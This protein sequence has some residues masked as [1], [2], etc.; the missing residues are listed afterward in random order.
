MWPCRC[1]PP[2]SAARWIGAGSLLVVLCA[3]P[4]LVLAAAASAGLTVLTRETNDTI[5]EGLVVVRLEGAIESPM[6]RELNAI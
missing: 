2:H 4:D 5:A 1:P 3:A 6:A